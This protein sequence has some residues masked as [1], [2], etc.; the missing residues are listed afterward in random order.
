[1]ANKM[2]QWIKN[3]PSPQAPPPQE[4]TKPAIQNTTENDAPPTETPNV[5]EK[6][7]FYYDL[8]S[9]LLNVIVEHQLED[10]GLSDA[11]GLGTGES[12]F[13]SVYQ[14]C[15]GEVE[16]SLT[17]PMVDLNGMSVCK[18]PEEYLFWD[19]FKLGSVAMEGIGK[20]VGTLVMDGKT[21]GKAW[22]GT[23]MGASVGVGHAAG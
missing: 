6:D 3:T 8:P 2:A 21:L 11:S 5:A 13:E 18:E 15:I 22:E 9:Y 1:M 14:P 17:D 4:E 7:I 10:E 20:E 12:P 16:V 23:N 19:G